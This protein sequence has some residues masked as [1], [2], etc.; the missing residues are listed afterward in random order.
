MIPTAPVFY[1]FEHK[2]DCNLQLSCTI[3]T[4][5]HNIWLFQQIL[6]IQRIHGKV[7]DS[8]SLMLHLSFNQ[9]SVCTFPILLSSHNHH[10]L[11]SRVHQQ[12]FELMNPAVLYVPSVYVFANCTSCESLY[13]IFC[14]YEQP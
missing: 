8:V 2:A 11:S 9:K 3:D 1:V 12:H 13:H 6:W 10:T 4:V 7:L 5:E 14:I